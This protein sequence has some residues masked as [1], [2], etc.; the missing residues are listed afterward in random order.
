MCLCCV[1]PLQQ[2]HAV[3]KY[4]GSIRPPKIPRTLS[5]HNKVAKK[6]T[7]HRTV[8]VTA[9]RTVQVTALR[10]VQVT[11]HRT[12]HVT[13]HRTV[14]VTAQPTVQVTAPHTVR[15]T[16][17]HTKRTTAVTVA[18]FPHRCY[19]YFAVSDFIECNMKFL[20]H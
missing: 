10:T 11:A 17:L 3:T 16:F 20:W 7:V 9:H 6:V 19:L 13:A 14:Q 4:E 1:F 15:V 8:Q 12:V 5:R 2:S 18:S